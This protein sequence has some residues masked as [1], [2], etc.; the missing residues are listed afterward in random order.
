MTLRNFAVSFAIGTG[1]GAIYFFGFIFIGVLL[2][3]G[4]VIGWWKSG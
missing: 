4:A 2:I 3:A 1:L